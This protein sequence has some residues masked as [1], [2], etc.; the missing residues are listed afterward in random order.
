[1]GSAG[2]NVSLWDVSKSRRMIPR[3]SACVRHAG[4]DA[5][6]RCTSRP[7]RSPQPS[8][9]W[10]GGDPRTAGAPQQARISPVRS[11]GRCAPMAPCGERWSGDTSYGRDALHHTYKG[12]T[13]GVGGVEGFAPLTPCR[14][15][16]RRP[17]PDAGQQPPAS[18]GEKKEKREK[19][20]MGS[21]GGNVS[22][23]DV[24]K[25]RRMI[26]RRSACVRHAGED[27]SRRCTSRPERSPQPSEPWRGG[28]P[29]TAGAPQQARIS[30]VRSAGRCA[31]MAPCGERWSGDT[32]YGRDALHHTYKG[33]T[34]VVGGVEGAA[35]LTPCRPPRR[36]PRPDAG[37]QP[38][39]GGE[40]RK[41]LR[42]RMT[43][44][45]AKPLQAHA[46]AG[47][48]SS[49][50]ARSSSARRTSSATRARWPRRAWRCAM[51]S[52]GCQSSPS[53]CAASR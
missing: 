5:S 17:R 27:A 52:H 4:E 10:R 23:W 18:G 39:S 13:G 6:R 47:R 26:P 50:P 24:S 14:P 32:S 36:R 42:Q 25:S 34:G 31:P 19:S 44:R 11:A 2:G 33:S 28:D 45:G 41:H 43:A 48:N 53:C 21:A 30:P 1:M 20:Q 46:P 40:K 35:P 29:R 38:R 8:E 37:Q 51:R 49:S 3:R 16:R 9:P 12:S 7:E 15:P 22:L